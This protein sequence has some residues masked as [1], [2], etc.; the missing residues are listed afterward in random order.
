MKFERLRTTGLSFAFLYILISVGF[1]FW[2]FRTGDPKGSF[3]LLQ[4]PIAMQ[5]SLFD[6]IGLAR[7]LTGIS[8]FGAY[9]IC[10]PPMLI[11]LYIAGHFLE[12]TLSIVLRIIANCW[13]N[14]SKST[15]S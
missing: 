5:L 13:K 14:H 15:E 11:I 6:E 10:V 7:F 1:I 12:V 8:W 2:S 9:I 4:I 3:V